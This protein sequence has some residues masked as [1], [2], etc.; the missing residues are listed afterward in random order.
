[1][2]TAPNSDI[3]KNN[4]NIKTLPPETTVG[5]KITFKD[6]FTSN[7][8]EFDFFYMTKIAKIYNL[9]SQKDYEKILQMS[10]DPAITATIKNNLDQESITSFEVTEKIILNN[11][12]E[13]DENKNYDKSF[14]ERFKYLENNG[15]FEVNPTELSNVQKF[16]IG[17]SLDT[18][19]ANNM[20]QNHSY[21]DLDKNPTYF[22]T[23]YELAMSHLPDNK[24]ILIE[25][26]SSKLLSLRK[27]FRDP[28]SLY[29]ESESGKT[30]MSFH[31][32]PNEAI[33]KIL[34]LNKI[35]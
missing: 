27:I 26:S 15:M 34:V 10:K 29:I 33:E 1:M 11:S 14:F 8:D 32:V 35:N 2:E 19:A 31:G 5:T 30:F 20:L 18:S 7:P 23:D 12:N 17:G 6:N 16:Y 24:P 21:G 22:T 25:I 3:I 4:I 13:Q 9:D 28:E